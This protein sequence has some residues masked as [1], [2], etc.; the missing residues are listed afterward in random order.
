METMNEFC[1]EWTRG[2]K[3]A[4][5]TAPN[6]TRI[7]SRI[8]KLKES[9][10]DEIEILAE[11]ED[12]SIFAHVPT[13]WIKINPPVQRELTDEQRAEIGERFRKYRESR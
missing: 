7:K 11:N 10:P 2:N 9:H 12:G 6:S 5:V 4:S 13:K 1:I 8:L 3:T